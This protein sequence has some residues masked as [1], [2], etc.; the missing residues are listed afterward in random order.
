MSMFNMTKRILVVDDEPLF[1]KHAARILSSAG[2]STVLAPNGK[3][4]MNHLATESFDAVVSDVIMPRM[5]GFE[6]LE[7]IRIRFPELPV[8]LMTA[9]SHEGMR[10]AALVC[11]AADLL[12][13]PLEAEKLIAAVESGLQGE[14]VA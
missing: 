6:L 1:L 12:E 2:C 8:I 11:G 9:S 14:L 13:K 7:S 3:E 5:T 10:E 4:A